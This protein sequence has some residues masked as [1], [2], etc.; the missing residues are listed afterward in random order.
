MFPEVQNGPSQIREGKRPKPGTKE[1]LTALPSGDQLFSGLLICLLSFKGVN[2]HS[3]EVV[4]KLKQ[5]QSE[6]VLADA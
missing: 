1:R 2:C 3:S 5:G 6:T 4:Y